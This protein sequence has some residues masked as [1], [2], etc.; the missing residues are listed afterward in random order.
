MENKMKITAAL[1]S[2]TILFSSV[3]AALASELDPQ[4]NIVDGSA[5]LSNLPLGSE[6]RA[7][8]GNLLD[9]AQEAYNHHNLY[10]AY[11]LASHAQ[12]IENHAG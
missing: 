4:Q 1:L 7:Q 8:A 3:G 10:Q 12:Q 9:Q 2:A 6:A 11:V 5:A